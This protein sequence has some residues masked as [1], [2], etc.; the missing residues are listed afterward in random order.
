M[1]DQIDV[2]EVACLARLHLSVEEEELFQEQ[3][4]AFVRHFEDLEDVCVD[5]VIPLTTPVLE[6]AYLREDKVVPWEDDQLALSN[7]P[8]RSGNL[9]RVPPVI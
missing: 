4:N 5:S 8:D 2:K 9:F 1:K 7:A 3:I 6:K